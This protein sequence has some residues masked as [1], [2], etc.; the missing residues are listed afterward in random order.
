[1]LCAPCDSPKFPGTNL[2]RVAQ[3]H[4]CGHAAD[5]RASCC[6]ACN[7]RGCPCCCADA[8]QSHECMEEH[9]QPCMTPAPSPAAPNKLDL[10]QPL[11]KS[12]TRPPPEEF[13]CMHLSC[14]RRG[15]KSLFAGFC[16]IST[17]RHVRLRFDL[18][19]LVRTFGFNGYVHA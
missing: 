3:P 5:T 14:Q 10:K 17:L 12:P 16:L 18:S 2:L 7:R 15:R 4:C 6:M 11:G 9:S 13:V 8:R 1:M 19:P